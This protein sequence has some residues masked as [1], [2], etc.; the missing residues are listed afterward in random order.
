MESA[1]ALPWPNDARAHRAIRQ[2]SVGE[3]TS[4]D[5]TVFAR[6]APRKGGGNRFMLEPRPNAP[7]QT[8]RG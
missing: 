6:S 4:A 7:L 2:R 3:A 5:R 8:L 1:E